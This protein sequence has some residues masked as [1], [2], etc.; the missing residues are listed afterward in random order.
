MYGVAIEQRIRRMIT[1][2]VQMHVERSPEH[3]FDFIADLHNEPKFN[4]DARD[5]VK[6][7]DGPIGLGTIWTENVKPLGAFT[8]RTHIY[9]RPSELGYDA[10]NRHAHITVRFA[11]APA[12]DGTDLRAEL[13]MRLQGPIR[14][15]E[16]I[17]RPLVI[18][19]YKR[20]RKP[21]VKQAL[22]AEPELAAPV[23]KTVVRPPSGGLIR[24]G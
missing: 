6:V 22:E 11:F 10:F 18:R 4:P 23:A 9:E 20:G 7:T 13:E 8:V 1:T 2:T 16:P 17:M 5:V 15:L 21:L 3:C 12:G 14:V 19:M 24:V